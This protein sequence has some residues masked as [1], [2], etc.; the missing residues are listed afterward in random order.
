[1]K[2]VKEEKKPAPKPI[3]FKVA[4]E[5]KYYGYKRLKSRD[6]SHDAENNPSLHK[7]Y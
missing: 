3:K 4:G 1:M 2:E 7:S 6:L 5:G